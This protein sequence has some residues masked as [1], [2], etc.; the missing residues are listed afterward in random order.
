M[1]QPTYPCTAMH[2]DYANERRILFAE[3]ARHGHV[4]RACA[5]IRMSRT[6]IYTWRRRSAEFRKLFDA[7]RKKGLE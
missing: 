4:S 3:L 1:P 5:A 7:A 2:A 6:T